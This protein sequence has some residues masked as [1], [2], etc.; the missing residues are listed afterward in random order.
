MVND[1]AFHRERSMPDRDPVRLGRR[2]LNARLGRLGMRL[3]AREVEPR[4]ATSA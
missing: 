2:W 4:P 1:V 3:T